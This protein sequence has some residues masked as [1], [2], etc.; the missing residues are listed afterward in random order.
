MAIGFGTT[1][2]GTMDNTTGDTSGQSVGDAQAIDDLKRKRQAFQ[3][4]GLPKLQGM[5][6]GVSLCGALTMPC[7]I[8]EIP[9]DLDDAIRLAGAGR[10]LHSAALRS[11]C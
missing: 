3:I 5:M 11:C 7:F 4:A 9:A 2:T 10:R 8:H 1:F 6:V